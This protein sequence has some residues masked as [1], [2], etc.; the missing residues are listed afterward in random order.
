MYLLSNPTFT[1]NLKHERGSWESTKLKLYFIYKLN[2]IFSTWY[3]SHIWKGMQEITCSKFWNSSSSLS[4]N[5]YNPL[6][7]LWND[8]QECQTCLSHGIKSVSILLRNN[9]YC[10]SMK[11]KI[12]TFQS[13][14]G[15]NYRNV[16][17]NH[18]KYHSNLNFLMTNISI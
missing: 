3:Q 12:Q 8:H 6:T 14:L 17:N 11:H 15:K 9:F 5:F 1:R 4:A 13:T 2:S 7:T 18:L 10:H 16:N